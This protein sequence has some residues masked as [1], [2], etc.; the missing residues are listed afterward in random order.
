MGNATMHADKSIIADPA[1]LAAMG[2]RLCATQDH[3]AIDVACDTL[4]LGALIEG[5]ST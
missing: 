1:L 3:D 5:G 4:L 2:V